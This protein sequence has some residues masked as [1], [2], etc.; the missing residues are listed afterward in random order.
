MKT[1]V[2]NNHLEILIVEDSPTQ[3]EQLRY[4][5]GK[6]SY[7]VSLTTNG[8]EALKFLERQV[9]DIVVSDIVMPEMDGYELCKQIRSD[10]R[11]KNVPVILV[12]RLSEPTD[13][14]KGLEAGANNFIT[15]PYD[16]KYIISHIEYLVANRELRENPASGT[17]AK[18]FFSGNTYHINAEPLQILDLLL[19]TY[20][21]AHRQNQELRTTQKQLQE[22]N[23]RLEEEKAKTE[24][25]IAAIGDGISIQD[26]DLTI[27]YQNQV[28]ISYFGDQR[29]RKC[30]EAYRYMDNHCHPCPVLA[31]FGN[32]K[33]HTAEIAAPVVNGTSTF[34][35]TTSSLRDAAGEII[36]VIE[37]ARN[38]D[39]RKKM[40]QER[41]ILI[42]DLQEALAN[43]KT[44]SG[45]LPIC[46]SC[47][48]I[49]DD[50]GYWNQIETYIKNH[51]DATF[52]HGICPDCM[53]K[54]Y[55]EVYEK[56][57]R[58]KSD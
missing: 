28:H 53:Q 14:I 32:G 17:G 18:V 10:A 45:L 15:K 12:T 21:N 38:I 24:S 1:S 13:V 47:K 51:S 57:Q 25:I 36:A 52:T 31:S 48:K 7:R 40:E 33:I 4:I 39:Q 46:A 44:L 20:E 54:L 30:Y 5:L 42:N 27:L 22:L 6:K 9:P 50:S 56:M 19:S 8:R 23:E 2:S 37:V 41:E 43:I 34:E 29:G 26:R 11:L 16:E 35:V 55:P 58:M 49:R 3:A